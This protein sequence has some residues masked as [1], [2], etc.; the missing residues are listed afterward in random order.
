VVSLVYSTFHCT[1]THHLPRLYFDISTFLYLLCIS[2]FPFNYI[3][4]SFIKIN[5]HHPTSNM[6]TIS[7]IALFASAITA[8]PV[9]EARQTGGTAGVISRD[10]IKNAVLAWR[11]GMSQVQQ[12][13]AFTLLTVIQILAWFQTSLTLVSMLVANLTVLTSTPGRRHFH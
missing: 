9:L 4:I 2:L 10:D 8:A 6:K 13:R 3:L 5:S 7:T 11:D 12:R 1:Q